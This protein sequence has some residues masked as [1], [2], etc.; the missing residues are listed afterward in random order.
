MHAYQR[1]IPRENPD[2]WGVFDYFSETGGQPALSAAARV[3]GC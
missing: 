2:P 3:L 1:G